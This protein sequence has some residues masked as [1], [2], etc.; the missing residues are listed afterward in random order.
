LPPATPPST[1]W[2]AAE[3]LVVPTGGD[4]AELPATMAAQPSLQDSL[5]TLLHGLLARTGAVRAVLLW[6]EGGHAGQAVDARAANADGRQ[7]ASTL[8][9]DQPDT[10]LKDAAEE[11]ID[12]GMA[13]GSDEGAQPGDWLNRAQ[14]ALAAHEDRAVLTLPLPGA[15]DPM[16][17]V[18]L[19]WPDDPSRRQAPDTS[20]LSQ[21]MASV[22]P[23]LAAQRRAERPWHWHA[24]QAWRQRRQ[25]WRQDTPRLQRRLWFA[26]GVG[27][28]LLA[29]VPMPERIGGSAR[30]EGAQQRVLAAPTDG[31]IKATHVHPGDRVKAGQV[32]A[33][34]AEQDLKLE[35][36]RWASQ[37]AQQDNSYAAAMTRADRAE[38][39]LALSR[40][41]EAQ[42]QLALIDEQLK[43][44]QLKAP[45]DGIVIQGDL[46]Q[47]IGA[48]VKQGDTLMTVAS[49][50]RFRVV[51]DIDEADV[52]RVRGG[53]SGR[54]ALSALPWDA[55]DLKVAR[56][57]PLG[58]ARDGRN[59]F[60]VQ[61]D[62]TQA[63]PADIR[64]G[65]TG[66]AKVVV[67]WRPLLWSWTRPLVN[68]LRF[69][70]WAW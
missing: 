32:L 64:P 69:L 48:P 6:Y 24:R 25:R 31:F 42:A 26:A 46:S 55:L 59:V 47:S 50:Q 30:I 20:V 43:R 53:Q 4:F 54:I 67:G 22:A 18:L 16:G 5:R 17:A 65:L 52:A 21:W 8:T 12:Q 40:L 3:G 35:R 11:A 41:E 1:A 49:T 58:V 61:A 39:A 7:P 10:R 28:L 38:A 62:F 51:I 37:V 29:L 36:D 2:Q 45:F 70:W 33:D 27:L 15:N 63:P 44:S 60:E 19:F 66:Q 68:R 34:L 57:T 13:V 23:L 14:Q 56:I 9:V